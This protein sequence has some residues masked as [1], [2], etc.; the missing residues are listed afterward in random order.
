ME[1]IGRMRIY[2][3]IKVDLKGAQGTLVAPA[4][5]DLEAD[6]YRLMGKVTET[7]ATRRGLQEKT[8]FF[9]IN[10]FA[11]YERA[12]AHADMV[13]R[14]AKEFERQRSCDVETA[15]QG[16]VASAFFID[17]SSIASRSRKRPIVRGRHATCYLARTIRSRRREK[18]MSLKEVGRMTHRDHTTV[19]HSVETAEQYIIDSDRFL[20]HKEFVQKL[21]CAERTLRYV[22][23]KFSHARVCE[24]KMAV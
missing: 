22:G 16:A 21:V 12:V 9:K 24:E 3:L 18:Q 15:I 1:K 6:L 2:P 10:D 4:Q 8:G 23:F 17:A 7:V 5:T 19:M 13:N 20:G 11:H 14:M